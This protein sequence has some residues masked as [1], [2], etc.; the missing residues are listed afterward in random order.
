MADSGICSHCKESVSPTAMFCSQ[1]GIVQIKNTLINQKSTSSFD[2]GSST[3]KPWKEPAPLAKNSAAMRGRVSKVV[4][5]EPWRPAM[6]QSK[7][8][9]NTLKGKPPSVPWP[10]TTQEV[11]S[12]S[13]LSPNGPLA[14]SQSYSKPIK[15]LGREWTKGG[16]VY[17]K[18]RAIF[19][20]F[21]VLSPLV[22]GK[23]TFAG[24]DGNTVETTTTDKIFPVGV[25]EA[26]WL[27][28]GYAEGMISVHIYLCERV[29]RSLYHQDVSTRWLRVGYVNDTSELQQM[30]KSSIGEMVVLDY[31][32]N[33]VAKCMGVAA[34]DWVDL[35]YIDPTNEY[36]LEHLQRSLAPIAR[37][38]V[39]N[40]G[41]L[42]LDQHSLIVSEDSGAMTECRQELEEE[43]RS[44]GRRLGRL[45]SGLNET[46]SMGSE[47][48]NAES[49]VLRRTVS[50][51]E[52]KSCESHTTCGL[53]L[54]NYVARIVSG[55][56]VGAYYMNRRITSIVYMKVHWNKRTPETIRPSLHPA[57][58]SVLGATAVDRNFDDGYNSS[59]DFVGEDEE[60]LSHEPVMTGVTLKVFPSYHMGRVL[61]P[62]KVYFTVKSLCDLIDCE[63]VKHDVDADGTDPDEEDTNEPFDRNAYGANVLPA[64]RLILRLLDRGTQG[65]AILCREIIKI[66]RYEHTEEGLRL[67]VHGIDNAFIAIASP[68]E[69]ALDR[70]RISI[71]ATNIQR[72]WRGMLARKHATS[73]YE[74]RARMLQYQKEVAAAQLQR[75]VRGK[76]VRGRIKTI[77]S[78]AQSQPS[79]PSKPDIE[80]LPEKPREF[81]LVT[82][83]NTEVELEMVPVCDTD[84]A[85]CVKGDMKVIV[86][87]VASQLCTELLVSHSDM[88]RMWDC[89]KEQPLQFE[90][91]LARVR[92]IRTADLR[93]VELIGRNDPFVDMSFGDAWCG[94]TSTIEEGGSNVEW[95]ISEAD[96]GAL[97]FPVTRDQLRDQKLKISVSDENTY[98]SHV[99]IGQ[100][101][102]DISV[103]LGVRYFG[104]RV[105]TTAELLNK[106]GKGSGYVTVTFDIWTYNDDS[107]V[108]APPPGSLAESWGLLDV[109]NRFIKYVATNHLDLFLSR[110]SSVF[111]LRL[112]M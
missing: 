54:E 40:S 15:Y 29:S 106:K 66:I 99:L 79:S 101:D 14:I 76:L 43:D 31:L 83:N 48:E 71:A 98:R 72:I 42:C 55:I 41:E 57:S 44:V 20:K 26:D 86:T 93:N 23:Q 82:L 107:E 105:A 2:P 22:G 64:G 36:M 74:E 97:Q 30:D 5:K 90:K 73:V 91:A 37:R 10:S 38:V 77:L 111:V 17:K 94:R 32:P 49:P 18:K 8:R 50:M 24:V 51:V 108:S 11:E 67:F 60:Y 104:D 87:E 92:H 12:G 75:L 58:A 19:S 78:I 81:L 112:K 16:G 84:S 3:A 69:R 61:K 53:R 1:C 27:P 46:L 21:M 63:S 4:H 13:R 34:D 95:D 65:A 39:L 89:F 52:K 45:S 103:L 62:K 68:E 9:A 59:D 80:S 47:S 96:Q 70:L 109:R 35:K 33:A 25:Y 7:A 28:M 102:M 88:L 6:K 85:E 100:C 110:A 56:P